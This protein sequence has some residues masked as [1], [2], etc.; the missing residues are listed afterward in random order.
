MDLKSKQGDIITE[1]IHAELEEDENVH[2][3]MPMGA[4]NKGKVLKLKKISTVCV[5]VQEIFGNS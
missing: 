4:G 5:K 2:V 1:F 3:D